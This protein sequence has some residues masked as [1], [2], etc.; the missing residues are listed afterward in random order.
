MAGPAVDVAGL[1]PGWMD[2]TLPLQ[3]LSFAACPLPKLNGV[4]PVDGAGHH[5]LNRSGEAVEGD[6]VCGRHHCLLSER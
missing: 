4:R 3:T 2:A 6:H 5:G 1:I